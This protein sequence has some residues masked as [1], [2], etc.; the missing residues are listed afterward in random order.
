MLDVVPPII[1]SSPAESPVSNFANIRILRDFRFLRIR[2]F[3]TRRGRARR[4]RYRYFYPFWLLR[5]APFAA[6]ANPILHGRG[7]EPH[8]P[9][10]DLEFGAL[11][12]I[13]PRPPAR[14]SI[15]G[16]VS[17]IS[18]ARRRRVRNDSGQSRPGG[19]ASGCPLGQ[20]SFL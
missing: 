17:L 18:H 14:M 16:C 1:L 9:F 13:A 2:R 7:Y 3:A 20:S 10:F 19:A 6:S 8:P 15:S 12:R 11:S 5:G 4:I